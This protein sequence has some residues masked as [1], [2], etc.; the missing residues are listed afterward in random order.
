MDTLKACINVDH[1]G[2]K[3]WGPPM[4]DADWHAFCQAI[5]KEVK[6]VS[7]KIH[8]RKMSKATKKSKSV[9]VNRCLR[10][11]GDV[12]SDLPI[13]SFD[14][15]S[16]C[17]RNAHVETRDHHNISKKMLCVKH[18]FFLCRLGQHFTNKNPK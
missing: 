6:E 18:I 5:K 11:R 13:K 14:D 4:V 16:K 15:N 17:I 10:R 8:D 2:E 1:M 12:A 7:G 9:I 3:F